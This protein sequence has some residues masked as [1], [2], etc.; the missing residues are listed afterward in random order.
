M[1]RQQGCLFQGNIGSFAG[2]YGREIRKTAQLF[3]RAGLYDFY[4]SDGHR[5]EPLKWC[6]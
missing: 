5:P 3:Q 6:L 2:Y 1:L 4:G